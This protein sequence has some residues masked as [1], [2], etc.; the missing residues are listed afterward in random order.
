MRGVRISSVFA[1]TSNS[2][3]IDLGSAYC[4]YTRTGMSV[5]VV[6]NMDEYHEME[7]FTLGKNRNSDAMNKRAVHGK[8]ALF[9]S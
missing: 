8:N 6:H 9:Y 4:L 3:L 5:L 2:I 1:M 7:F